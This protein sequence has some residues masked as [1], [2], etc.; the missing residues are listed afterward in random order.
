MNGSRRLSLWKAV[1]LVSLGVLVT[2]ACGGSS[3]SD[4][5]SGGSGASGAA[6]GTGGSGGTTTGGAGGVSTGGASSGGAAGGG[7]APAAC[8]YGKPVQVCYTLTELEWMLSHPPM[9]GDTAGEAGDAG[10]GGDA[11][12]AGVKLTECPAFTLVQNDCCVYAIAGPEKKAD[13]CCYIFCDGVCC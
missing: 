10:D 8:T 11:S 3:T 4:A 1:G 5:A 13:T 12:D 7:A 9:G 6:G 2:A